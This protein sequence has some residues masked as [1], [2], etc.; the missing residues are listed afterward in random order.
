MI[1]CVRCGLYV[2]HAWYVCTTC[3]VCTLRK[4]CVTCAVRAPWYVRCVLHVLYVRYQ[5]TLSNMRVCEQ[6]VKIGH[7]RQRDLT[8]L[9]GVK[10]VVIERPAV[11]TSDM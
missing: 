4:V 2:R 7:F 8:Q 5:H 1:V 11:R 6:V 10:P 3:L 9:V